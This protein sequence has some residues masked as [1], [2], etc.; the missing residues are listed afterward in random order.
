MSNKIISSINAIIDN[1][2]LPA[3]PNNVVAIDTL[4]SR[5]GVGTANPS[6]EID[7]SGTIETN[8]LRFK[9]LGTIKSNTSNNS[10]LLFNT[11]YISTQTI[12]LSNIR[13]NNISK[14]NDFTQYINISGDISTNGQIIVNNDLSVNDKL[15]VQNDVSFNSNLFVENDISVNRNINSLKLVIN[16]ICVNNIYCNNSNNKIDICANLDLS[17]DLLIDGSASI[18]GQ[19]GGQFFTLTSDD[20]L[21]H[22]EVVINNGLNVVNKLVP[23]LYQKTRNFKAHDFSGIVNEPYIIEAGLIAQELESLDDISFC[24]NIGS[25]VKPYSVNYNNI[26]VYGLAAIKEL[27]N[28]INNILDNSNNSNNSNNSKIIQLEKIISTQNIE[29][30]NLK[31][32]IN[33]LEKKI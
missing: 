30:N 22:N 29:I 33:N 21:K 14:N 2:T 18:L 16:D 25:N 31:K 5:I 3:N 6:C 23:Q 15:F 7:V 13:L 1:Q 20:R 32:R 24:V 8:I 26:F 17:G 12:E 11:N 9:S 19:I 27:D 4:H 10:E 28:K